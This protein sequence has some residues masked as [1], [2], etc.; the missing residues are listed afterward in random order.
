MPRFDKTGPEGS[1]PRTGRGKGGCSPD[2]NG[3]F[4]TPKPDEET[5]EGGLN[6]AKSKLRKIREFLTRRSVLFVDDGR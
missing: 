5:P 6:S 2:S 4:D 1:G 3:D